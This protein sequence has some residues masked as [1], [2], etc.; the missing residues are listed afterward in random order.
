MWVSNPL[1]WMVCVEGITQCDACWRPGVMTR[2]LPFNAVIV[3]NEGAHYPRTELSE[4]HLN[5]WNPHFWWRGRLELFPEQRAAFMW[6]DTVLFSAEKEAAFIFNS[7]LVKQTYIASYYGLSPSEQ[8]SGQ[9]CLPASF[10]GF[11]KNVIRSW[12]SPSSIE[13]CMISG[14]EEEIAL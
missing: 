1:V 9:G 6:H 5:G 3:L 11:D 12:I 2:V 10:L 14:E 13:G 7:N 8:H 4:R